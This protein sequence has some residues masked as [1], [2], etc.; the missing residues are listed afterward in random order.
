MPMIPGHA[1]LKKEQLDQKKGRV[2]GSKAKFSEQEYE[3]PKEGRD[4][5]GLPLGF[6]SLEVFMSSFV[7]LS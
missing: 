2:V 3:P 4:P 6:L 1:A 7:E 5:T